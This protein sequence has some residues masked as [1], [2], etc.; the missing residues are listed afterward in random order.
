[1]DSEAFPRGKLQVSTSESAV[2]SK[3]APKD[4]RLFGARSKVADDEATAK[5]EKSKDRGSSKH[6][7]GKEKKR[8]RSEGVHPSDSAAGSGH[9]RADELSAKVRAYAACLAV[10]IP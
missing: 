3:S 8:S 9:G 10:E 1:M 4:D 7:E 5:R 2:P 6:V